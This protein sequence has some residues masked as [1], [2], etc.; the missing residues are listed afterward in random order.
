MTETK[1][2][3]MSKVAIDTNILLYSIDQFDPIKQNKSIELIAQSPYI[4]SQMISEFSNVCLRKWKFPKEKVGA[5]VTALVNKCGF[6][7]VTRQIILQTM[8]IMQKYR[9]QFFDAIII[10]AALNE[11][12][13]TLYSEDMH[14]NLLVEKSLRIINPFV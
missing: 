12:C 6:I 9:L 13:K 2:T 11:G 5:I 1:L 10:T 8:E 4:S 3:I 14:H 7:P